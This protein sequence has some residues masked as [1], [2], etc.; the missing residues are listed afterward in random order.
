[1]TALILTGLLI[2]GVRL[3]TPLL[4]AAL[5]EVM[6]ERAG[7]INVGIEGMVLAG[8]L[9]G[10]T[11]SYHTHSPWLGVLAAIAAGMALALLFALFAVRLRA[12]QVISGTAINILA[13]GLTGVLFRAQFSQSG[14]SAVAFE[15]IAIPGLHKLPVIGAAFFEQNILG[16]L[17]WL[18]VPACA[19]FLSKTVAG[20]RLRATGE[21]PEAAS[22]SGVR[23]PR[24]RTLAILWGGALAG[25]AGAYLSIAY[26]NG[27]VENMSAGRGFIALAVVILGRWRPAGVLIAAL[28]FGLASALQYQFQ[29]SASHIPYQFFLALPYL[30][31]LLALL[32]R[33]RG[34]FAAPAALG[35]GA[36]QG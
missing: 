34:R 5:G 21:Y 29:A 28:L 4:L 10:F 19:L 24:V 27:F 35:E 11:V 22:A 15:P 3:A 26:T 20:L 12:D 36:R 25:L 17:S 16:Y 18:L 6:A 1:M 13:L 33:G 32:L 14:A 2:T 23:V 8:A 7:V 9:A 30:L 31:T